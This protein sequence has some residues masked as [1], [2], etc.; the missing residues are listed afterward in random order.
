MES[1]KQILGNIEQNPQ[2]ADLVAGFL[3]LC[4]MTQN[5][6]EQASA[7]VTCAQCLLPAQPLLSMR[8]LQLALILSPRSQAGL[9][10][11]QELFK[12]R[13]RWAA[14]QRVAEFSLTLSHATATVLMP[15]MPSAAAPAL[16]A[17]I[18]ADQGNRR[19]V[20]EQSVP[21]SVSAEPARGDSPTPAAALEQ[22][23]VEKF[24]ALAGLP[25]DLASLSLGFSKNNS[26]LVAFVGLLMGS[27]KLKPPDIERSAA[28]LLKMIKENPDDSGAEVLFE[29]LFSEAPSSPRKEN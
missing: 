2:R 6:M 19:D 5:P 28:L 9:S 13:G 8:V 7:L 15:A 29:R 23:A 25:A 27:G 11:A 1:W 18:P 16:D 10:L 22:S 14:E 4:R 26:G 12:R 17:E 3:S 24:L 21:S 20:K